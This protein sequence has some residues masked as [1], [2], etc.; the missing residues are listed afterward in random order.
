MKLTL[1]QLDIFFEQ[2]LYPD[3]PIY[4]IGAK[5][6]IKGEICAETFTKAYHEMI[7]Q[8]DAYRSF[9]RENE[10][11]VKRY[12]Y[13]GEP[14]PLEW[15]DFSENTDAVSAAEDY[16]QGEFLI[17]FNVLED[18][19]LYRFVLIKAAADHYYLF[20]VY[21][22]IITDGWGTSLMFQ[23]LI[24]NYNDILKLN[25]V[26]DQYPYE[27]SSFA[28]HDEAYLI[29]DEFN[30]DKQYWAERFSSLPQVI[31][32]GNETKDHR[33]H[34]SDRK[35][36]IV[37]REDYNRFIELG[38][39]HN[40]STFH[41]FLGLFFFYFG[42][43][44][45]SDDLAIGIPV[46]N[47]NTKAFKKTVG[48]FMGV[49]PLRMKLND[50]NSLLELIENTR[51]QL[52]SDYRYQK[53][54]LGKMISDLKLFNE[55]SRLFN[56]T[57]SYEKHN[58]ADHFDGTETTVIP[59]TNKSERS[60]LA[61]YV[62]EFDDHEDIK[63]DFDYNTDVFDGYSI[64]Q[65]VRHIDHLIVNIETLAGESMKKISFLSQ[66]ERRTLFSFNERFISPE[67][68]ESTEKTFLDLFSEKVS[69]SPYKI[70]I[71]DNKFNLSYAEVDKISSRVAYYLLNNHPD[72]KA[73]AVLLGRSAHMVCT[74]LGIMKAG[75]AYIPLDP[76]FPVNRLQ[77]ILKNSKAGLLISDKQISIHLT[78]IETVFLQSILNTDEDLVEIVI[79]PEDTAYIIY[80]SGS[81]GNPKGVEIGHASLLN[82]LQ[83]ILQKPGVHP[84]DIVYSITT[85]SFDIS[86]LEFFTP[87]MSG[88][89]L[90]MAGD[91]TLRHPL[92][93]IQEILEVKPSIIQATPSF[94]KRLLSL[95][96]KPD[97]ELKI[98][99]GG[100]LINNDLI[101]ELLISCKE[102]WNM[103]GPT[104]TTI[105]S[106][107]KKIEHGTSPQN[108]GQPIKET[109]FYILDANLNLLPVNSL[110][111]IYIG[112]KGLAKG[113]YHNEALSLEKFVKN[114]F[115]EGEY[116]YKTGDV[117]QW[118]ENGEIIFLGRSDHQVK[119]K[120]YRIELGDIENH[121]NTIE[122][123]EDSV[124]VVKEIERENHLVAYL[125]TDA[126]IEMSGVHEK[127]Q[128]MLPYYMVPHFI[129][130]I[131]EFPLTPNKKIDRQLLSSKELPSDEPVKNQEIE[132]PQL[133]RQL[134]NIWKEVLNS[135]ED[136][137][138]ED[139]FFELGGHSMLVTKL[140]NRVNRK[141][142]VHLSMKEVFENPDLYSL[143]QVILQEK[144][145]DNKIMHA[146][147]QEVIRATPA[148]NNIWLACQRK[149]ASPSYNM[150]M[151]FDVSG[152]VDLVL[153]E[154]AIR[155]IIAANEIVRTNFILKD[156]T[157]SQKINSAEHTHFALEINEV[158]DEAEYRKIIDAYKSYC[159]DFEQ[160]LLLKMMILKVEDKYKILFLTHHIIFD[161]ISTGLFIKQLVSLYNEY[162]AHRVELMPE[163]QFR[164]YAYWYYQNTDLE[165]NDAF[166]K[167][168]TEA[169]EYESFLK[170]E[171]P[172]VDSYEGN[173][174]TIPLD[175]EVS[176]GLTNLAKE[177]KTTPYLLM[178]TSLLVFL[179]NISG[180]TDI[181]IATVDSGRSVPQVES[182]LGIFIKS[183]LL[184]V[185]FGEEKLCEMLQKVTGEFL[186]VTKYEEVSDYSFVKNKVDILFVAQNPEF[187][188]HT[189][190]DFAGFSLQT[191]PQ[192]TVYNKFPF[193]MN[194]INETGEIHLEISYNKSLY[195]DHVI[196]DF[197]QTYA[198]FLKYLSE[199]EANVESRYKDFFYSKN[200]VDIDFDF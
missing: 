191:V 26:Q 113:Y 31:F 37:S 111:D 4:N 65:C 112:G 34:I 144:D 35:E 134:K 73:I 119:I 42:R 188:Y 183:M 89:T 151:E 32:N 200:Q 99:C 197:S 63:I 157:V 174:L 19:Y 27:Y 56:I 177:M 64:E 162:A 108:I 110:G 124:V 133:V 114:P 7:R 71:A 51:K 189:I 33:V 145:G 115:R 48:L 8:H 100:D 132:D 194:I 153:L 46:L 50:E 138:D 172:A 128:G 91:K 66:E 16:M 17:P 20:S 24:K 127:L 173:I 199:L 156:E 140:I 107:V 154:K 72:E 116:I 86:I 121:L 130:T 1:P 165:K 126:Q 74:L 93:T 142:F 62:R 85:Y 98:L 14:R 135:K 180:K 2:M 184:R 105:W 6:E 69:E 47:R 117:G 53:Y 3:I 192:N 131:E 88:A 187:S 82:L 38:K 168:Y 61:I 80:T 13:E 55:K 141:F 79:K 159:F 28:A 106:S 102:L 60:A 129:F 39:K 83:S 171:S 198:G 84:E 196:T 78:D 52:M 175:Q 96:W 36:L 152:A 181:C 25:T 150:F 15:V 179:R 123:I 109:S 101:E 155:H 59:L 125:K 137:Q 120:G 136:I 158:H 21:H 103:Y 40:F 170:K 193:I 29:S 18:D 160:E 70:A 169:Y 178:L 118:N 90:Y 195:K 161:G 11:E 143:C 12:I 149:G 163:I 10:N 75:K 44:N 139:N 76:E 57:F 23:R 104:E 186:E 176:K 166:W 185:K 146:P 164:D 54:P 167:D 5:I 122:N 68:S 94:F 97:S 81:T 190:S 148:Q 45:Q 77:Y 43:I 67:E 22:H 87:L 9:F 92:A 58:Y 95:G 30:R 147:Y 49:S 182:L 41:G